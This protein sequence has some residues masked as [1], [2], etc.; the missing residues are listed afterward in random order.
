MALSDDQITELAKLPKGVAAVYQMIGL[1]LF[2]VVSKS[3]K[4]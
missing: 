4:K 3:L 2:F 1:K